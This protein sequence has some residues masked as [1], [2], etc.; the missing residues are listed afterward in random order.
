[1]SNITKHDREQEREGDDREQPR[2]DLL[3]LCDTVTVHDGLV[4]FRELVGSVKSRRRLMRGQLMQDGRN[5]RARTLLNAN[6]SIRIQGR[7]EDKKDT[8]R[9]RPQRHLNHRNIPRRHPPLR[10]E[11]LPAHII[12]EQVQ[13]LI[14]HLLLPNHILPAPQA[15]PNIH[16]HRTSVRARVIQHRLQVLKPA[17]DLFQRIRTL[18]GV[19]VDGVDRR[20]HG[21]GDLADLG[22]ESISM[23][24]DDEHV[25]ANLCAS[26]A[27]DERLGNV[28]VVHVEIATQ[29]A[30][31][32]T[33]EGRQA[34]AFDGACDESVPKL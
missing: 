13:R 10:N 24:E 8:N 16:Q 26:R 11:R 14:N 34:R 12:V 9:S 7:K 29:H 20:A 22:E 4:P 18:V 5:A 21:L 3:V 19:G 25:L 32:D 15:L 6:I 30:P 31:E 28:D 33:F 23:C 1:M 27:V 2:V 17:G